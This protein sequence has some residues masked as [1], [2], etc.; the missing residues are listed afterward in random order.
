MHVAH[1]H[2]VHVLDLVLLVAHEQAQS[3]EQLHQLL[4]KSWVLFLVAPRQQQQQN[5]NKKQTI[6]LAGQGGADSAIYK[7]V[8]FPAFDKNP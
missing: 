1:L 7:N 4:T 6:I 8:Y 3:G 2:Q 5:N